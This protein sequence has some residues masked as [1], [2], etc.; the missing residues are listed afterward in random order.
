LIKLIKV[1]SRFVLWILCNGK[2][3]QNGI[4]SKGRIVFTE[5]AMDPI[6]SLCKKSYYN[7]RLVFVCFDWTDS[8]V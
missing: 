4:L 6:K 2:I 5:S 1:S 7:P 8:F 3:R